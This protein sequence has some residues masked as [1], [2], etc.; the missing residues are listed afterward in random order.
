MGETTTP[1]ETAAPGTDQKAIAE[2]VAKALEASDA[3]RRERKAAKRAARESAASA[4]ATQA[5]ANAALGQGTP[6]TAG[7]S[8]TETAEQRTARL[9]ALADQKFAEAAAREGL[10]VTETD[11]QI[12]ER[13][14]EEKMVPLR[15][16]RAE[17]GDVKRKGIA[18]LEALAESPQIGK[19][20]QEASNEDLKYAAGAAFGPKGAR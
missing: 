2:A 14:I 9:Q 7:A 17:G 18:Q 15:Q 3:A 19:Q 4:N 5:A 12:L 10:A 1:A 6:A 13:M 8:A 20:L 11:E 16:A